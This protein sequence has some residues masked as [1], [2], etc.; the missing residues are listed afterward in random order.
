VLLRL[1]PDNPRVWNLSAI[2][3]TDIA[4]PS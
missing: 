4:N 2:L 3:P 1:A